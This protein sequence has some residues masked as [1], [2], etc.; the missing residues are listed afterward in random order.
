MYIMNSHLLRVEK[1]EVAD[2]VG[3]VQINEVGQLPHQ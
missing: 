3:G 2:D 1:L